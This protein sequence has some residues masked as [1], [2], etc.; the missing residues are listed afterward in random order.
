MEMTS[1]VSLAADRS[2]IQQLSG[3]VGL[4]GWENSKSIRELLI[5]QKGVDPDGTR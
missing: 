3:A 1:V 4:S 2:D 5:I